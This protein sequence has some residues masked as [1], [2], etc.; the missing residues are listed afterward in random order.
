MC[1]IPQ[2]NSYPWH[3]LISRHKTP[4]DPSCIKYP[5]S[6]QSFA[7]CSIYFFLPF[8]PFPFFLP[9][10]FLNICSNS[11]MGRVRST[12][13]SDIL[14]FSGPSAG[15]STVAPS[16]PIR[17]H[18]RSMEVKFRVGFSM[19]SRSIS[20]PRISSSIYTRRSEHQSVT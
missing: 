11:G 13:N 6:S 18:I 4:T 15:T 16:S 19:Q 2:Y 8:L 5:T 10:S 7:R 12:R 14:V 20:R 3:Q 9:L 17:F 1:T